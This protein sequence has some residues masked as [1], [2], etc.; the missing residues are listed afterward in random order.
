MKIIKLSILLI[1][2]A[3]NAC[4]QVIITER[5]TSATDREQKEQVVS[6][7]REISPVK[8][9]M[10]AAALPGLGQVYNRKYWKIPLV[11]AGFGALGYSIIRNS[12]NFD[13]YLGAYQ[14]ITDEIPETRSY[15]TYTPSFDS[16]EID[17][18][19]GADNYNPQT[20]SWVKDQM[21]NAISYYRRYRDLSYIGV[22]F[23]YIL[24]ILDAN[25]DA[26]MSDWEINPELSLSVNPVAIGTVY[27]PT[28]GLGVK[29]TF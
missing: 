5:D 26:V 13:A 11:Y 24:S 20:H 2:L 18:A 23:W 29:V 10:M 7:R 25:V 8:A 9:T 12:Q 4:A 21:L 14:D 16:G 1:I 22:G 28:M 27:G 3:I 19:L 6:L 17:P 15:E